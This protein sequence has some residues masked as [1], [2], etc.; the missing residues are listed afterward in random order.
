MFGAMNQKVHKMQVLDQI[1]RK[2]LYIQYIDNTQK[3]NSYFIIRTI[4]KK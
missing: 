1:L 3:K 2:V 4:K